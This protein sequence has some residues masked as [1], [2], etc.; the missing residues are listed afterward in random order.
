[1]ATY[2]GLLTGDVVRYSDEFIRLTGLDEYELLKGTITDFEPISNGQTLACMAWDGPKR[3][4]V[5]N[6]VQVG[7]LM[8]GR[9]H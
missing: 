8:W 1:M 7:R 4:N 9:A 5:N 6:L 2:N 3:V